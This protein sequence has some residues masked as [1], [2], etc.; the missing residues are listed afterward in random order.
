M[1]LLA[2]TTFEYMRPRVF[3]AAA[4][5]GV[6]TG[7]DDFLY[8]CG[9]S[10]LPV[11]TTSP[12]IT[13]RL[14][15]TVF[16]ATLLVKQ[17]FTPYSITTLYGLVLSMTYNKT[18]QAI[19]YTLVTNSGQKGHMRTVL[20]SS[21]HLRPPTSDQDAPLIFPTSTFFSICVVNYIGYIKVLSRLLAAIYGHGH[22]SP[23]PGLNSLYFSAVCVWAQGLLETV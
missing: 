1:T 14:G 7:V 17:N 4:V 5:I 2:G 11:S 8:A 18:K 19:T 22:G 23:F 21:W 10:S 6:L 12:I 9:I 16:F 3:F 20:K 13:S 15:F